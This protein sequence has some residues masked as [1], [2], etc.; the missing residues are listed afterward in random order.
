VF[1]LSRPKLFLPFPGGEH[2]SIGL[3]LALMWPMRR[4]HC[5]GRSGLIQFLP[6]GVDGIEISHYEYVC[7]ERLTSVLQLTR[8]KPAGQQN[9]S[10]SYLAVAGRA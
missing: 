5:F 4:V 10:E 7:G 9:M 3:E 8:A 6:D 1:S 2:V